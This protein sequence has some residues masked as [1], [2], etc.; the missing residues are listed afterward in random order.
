MFHVSNGLF[1]KREENGSVTI[2]KTDGKEPANDGSNVAFQE[3]LDE[4]VW[5]SAVATVSAGNE[6]DLRWYA[7]KEFHRSTG[8]I[9]CV[10]A[11][12]WNG[13]IEVEP[14]KIANA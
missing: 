9:R 8:Q 1:F 4:N 7:A 11:P 3:T 2:L 6:H 10:P 5:C 13:Q 12:D 14:I